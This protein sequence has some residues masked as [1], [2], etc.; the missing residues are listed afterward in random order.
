[1]DQLKI[2]IESIGPMLMHSATF[3]DP[4]DVRTQAHKS[5]TSKRKKTEE[6]QRAIAKSEFLSSLYYDEKTG[7][8]IPGINVE[9]C[10]FEAAKLR[11][12]GKVA[13]RAI[14]VSEDQIKVIYKG[15][16]DP[17]DL[18]QSPEFVDARAVK[19]ST[20]KIIRYRPKFNEWSARFQLNYN[21][22]QINR[23]DILDVLRDAGSLIGIGDFRPRFGK[24]EVTVLK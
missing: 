9:S 10:I 20:S 23:E 15:P 5:L 7:V 13:K 1:M 3:A 19:V 12:L 4:L 17:L 8:F 18:W 11:K 21:P 24:F 16:K 2:E 6:D 22:E 14:L